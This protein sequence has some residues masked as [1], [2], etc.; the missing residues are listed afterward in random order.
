M[1]DP[2]RKTV[3]SSRAGALFDN[4]KY[5]TRWMLYHELRG[6]L[7]SDKKTDNRMD[8]GK[9]LQSAVL[10][11][12]AEQLRLEVLEI[13][14]GTYMRAKDAPLGMTGDGFA[15]DP[16]QGLIWVEVKTVDGLIYRDEWTETT[17]PVDIEAQVQHELAVPFPTV[18]DLYAHFKPDNVQVPDGLLTMAQ[19]I[20]GQK[21]SKAYIAVLVGGNEAHLMERLPIESTQ[22][23]L[24]T[25]AAAM[26]AL[27]AEGKEPPLQGSPL[28]IPGLNA[29]Y[30][31]QGTEVL[32][33]R[34]GF[35]DEAVGQLLQDYML[36]RE[37]RLQCEKAEEQ[38]KARIQGLARD[39]YG[40]IRA[41]GIQCKI[42]KSQIAESVQTRKAHT[43]VALSPK[44]IE[45]EGE[46]AFGLPKSVREGAING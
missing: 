46:G 6:T 32:D 39:Q 20:G 45:G 8:W 14:H 13:P 38:Y 44:R 36:T 9:R 5:A 33:L 34:G 17:A 11:W 42:S 3:S 2:L 27:V 30:P 26:M 10:G 4:S 7:G 40:L 28:E 19:R 16:Q 12:T 23:A 25:E 31:R 41:T 18:D 1:P 21:A 15:W 37:Q 35:D 22:A 24:R 29:I 43:R